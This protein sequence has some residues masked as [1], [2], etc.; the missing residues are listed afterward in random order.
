MAQRTA[1]SLEEAL[2]WVHQNRHHVSGNEWNPARG[3]YTHRYFANYHDRLRVSMAKEWYTAFLRYLRPN[4]RPHDDRVFALTPMG[5]RLLREWDHINNPRN[6][7]DWTAH[8]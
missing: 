6:P 5:R 2:M 7:I 1:K 8:P 4:P 3:C